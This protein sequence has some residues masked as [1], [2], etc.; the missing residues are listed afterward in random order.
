MLVQK[1]FQLSEA[2]VSDILDSDHLPIVLHL[3]G[4]VRTRNL[5]NPVDKFTH[6]EWFQSLASELIS[7]G[8]Q[9]H[10]GEEANKVACDVTVSIVLA[11]RLSTSKS[12]QGEARCRKYNRLKFGSGQAYNRSVD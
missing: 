6:W 8:I 10:L 4:H 2:I 3:M 11:Y 7:L 12:R 9:I 1:N 5:L